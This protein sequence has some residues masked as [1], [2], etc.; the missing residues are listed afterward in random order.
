MTSLSQES[1]REITVEEA[2]R[3]LEP[4]I[5]EAFAPGAAV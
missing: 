4:L 5:R 2:A 3:S 1:G